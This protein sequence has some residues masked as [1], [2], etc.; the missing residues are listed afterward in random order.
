M[1]V[2]NNGISADVIIKGGMS[3]HFDFK[4]NWLGRVIDGYG[5][6]YAGNFDMGSQEKESQQKIAAGRNSSLQ[7]LGKETAQTLVEK[8]IETVIV[9]DDDKPATIS[10]SKDA[11]IEIDLIDDDVQI[12]GSLED[13]D[14]E[15]VNSP[16]VSAKKMA[17]NS[18]DCELVMA[19]SPKS[20]KP[21]SSRTEL[22]VTNV[23]PVRLSVDQKMEI[24]YK[25]LY[26][27]G[28]KND[29]VIR[30]R[31]LSGGPTESSSY[32]KSIQFEC[33][34][35]LG[36][37]LI[38]DY[39]PRTLSAFSLCEDSVAHPSLVGGVNTRQLPGALSKFSLC[40][41]SMAGPVALNVLPSSLQTFIVE[42][43]KF[44]GNCV[45][46]NLPIGLFELSLAENSFTGSL[47]LQNLPKT[48]RRLK[49]NNNSFCGGFACNFPPDGLELLDVSNNSLSSFSYKDGSY[50]H[51]PSIKR[52]LKA[53]GN[54]ISGDAVI[55]GGTSTQFHLESNTIRRVI[56][57]K[58]NELKLKYQFDNA[59]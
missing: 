12:I 37:T 24:F 40:N 22:L 29:S 52:I 48:L 44:S 16:Q 42:R 14:V 19:V 33:K 32:Q 23:P 51:K 9:I 36:G 18:D 13:S 46:G 2:R 6:A 4:H 38:P 45:L 56:D 58:G 20:S 39:L 8:T 26:C 41:T 5:N 59:A 49:L 35:S 3:T 28:Q 27:E 43:N 10:H 54:S 25:S 21:A 11:H 30:G 1:N 15:I 17:V 55:E 47:D 7:I 53:Q 31:F 50:L 57:D 34:E